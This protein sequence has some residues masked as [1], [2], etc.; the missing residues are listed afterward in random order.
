M[1]WYSLAGR[2]AAVAQKWGQIIQSIMICGNLIV[3]P[4]LRQFKSDLK[5][6]YWSKTFNPKLRASVAPLSR[7]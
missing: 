1:N 5:A 3:S 7:L 6:G 2:L 4:Y